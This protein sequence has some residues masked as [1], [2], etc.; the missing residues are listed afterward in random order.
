[1]SCTRGLGTDLAN[2]FGAPARRHRPHALMFQFHSFHIGISR[3]RVAA[4]AI[5]QNDVWREQCPLPD[6]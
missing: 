6:R 2:A 5:L 1:M 4:I 3:E